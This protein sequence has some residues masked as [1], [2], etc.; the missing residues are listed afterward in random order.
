MSSTDHFHEALTVEQQVFRLQVP[1]HDV[2]A[3]QIVERLHHARY[4]ETRGVVVETSAIPEERPHLA[5]Q[6]R[7]HQHVHVSVVLVR[8]V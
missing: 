1:V 8:A 4:H 3:V 5:A 7:L 2:R 6:T